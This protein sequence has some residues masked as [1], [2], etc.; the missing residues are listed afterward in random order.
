MLFHKRLGSKEKFAKQISVIIWLVQRRSRQDN[1][2]FS[3]QLVSQEKISLGHI[4]NPLLTKFVSS[5][6]Y[7]MLVSFLLFCVFVEVSFHKNAE[8][9]NL[10]NIQP[11]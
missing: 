4:I 9:K 8:K 11:S 3:A 2:A 10:A 1:P 7:L 6:H 5:I